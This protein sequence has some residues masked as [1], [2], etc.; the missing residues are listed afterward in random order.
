MVRFGNYSLPHILDAQIQK[1][2]I[3]IERSV[4]SRGV[5]YRVDQATRGQTIKVS[6]EIR[7][8]T[9]SE[10]AFGIE[11]LRRLADD[12][13]RLF[14]FED[15]EPRPSTRNLWILRMSYALETGSTRA[16]ATYPIL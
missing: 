1:S 16:A 15:G 12:T 5:A 7:A 3:E 14:D 11:H 9:I 13:E 2:R 8:D 4:P 6:G 10:A